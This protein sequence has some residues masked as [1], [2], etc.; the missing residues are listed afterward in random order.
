MKYYL[1]AGEASG[2]LHASNLIKALKKTDQNASFRAF[3]GDLMK[4]A[5]ASLFL[6]YREMAL[7]GLVEVVTKLGTIREHKKACRQDILEWKPDVL[8]LVDYSGFNLPM[9]RFACKKNI[10]VIYYISPKLWAWAQWRVKTIRKCVKRMFVILPFEVE[11]YKQHEVHA[12]YYGNPV[13]DSITEY[14]MTPDKDGE[15]I[16]KYAAGKPIIALL[17]G[18]RKQEIN[19]LL[20]EMLAIIPDFPDYKFIIAGAPSI[21]NEYY[22]GLIKDNPV[23]IVFNQTYNLLSHS[24]AAVVTSGTATLETALLN[25]PEV[26]I[27]KTN[28][29]TL[30]IGRFLVKV[31]FFSLVNLILDKEAVKELL[32]ENLSYDISLELKKI[33]S[34]ESYRLNMLN[35]FKKLREIL[36]NPGVADRVATRISQ[37]MK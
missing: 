12:E 13:L 8:I 2:D 1:I 30:F 16:R 3:G 4:E 14:R 22:Q 6:H 23:D 33:L 11:F 19:A 34:D 9:A 15:F 29:V 31:K 10:P 36:G 24:A 25:V 20:P 17:A 28:P 32:Q 26:V 5:G 27:Y 21:T 18:S 37:I 35:D 7:M